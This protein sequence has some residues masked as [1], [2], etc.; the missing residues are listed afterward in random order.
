[1][2]I[3]DYRA[4]E[5]KRSRMN[6]LVE[7]EHPEIEDF[8]PQESGYYWAREYESDE[9]WKYIVCVQG[10]P[11]MLRIDSIWDIYDGKVLS[12]H[13]AFLSFGPKIEK[14]DIPKSLIRKLP[15]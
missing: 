13:K 5:S 3:Q 11:P 8:T 4:H 12:G 14:P 10:K 1:M 15:S 9:Y 6:E 2:G 7:T